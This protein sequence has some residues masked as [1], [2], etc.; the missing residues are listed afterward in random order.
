MIT[1]IIPAYNE[2]AVIGCLLRQLMPTTN[3]GDVEIIVVAN[4]C[5]DDTAKIAASFGPPV[6]VLT[7]PTASKRDALTV[8][9]REACGFPRIYIDADVEL[10][11]SGIWALSSA[12]ETDGVLAALPV[13]VVDVADSTWPVRWYYDIWNRVPTVQSGLFGRGVVAVNETGHRRITELPPLLADDL[14]ASLAFAD[15]ER[16]IVPEARVIVHAPRTLRDHLRRRMRV[17]NGVIQLEH[18]PG[19]PEMVARTRLRD[20]VAIIKCEPRCAPQMMIFLVVTLI[21]RFMSRRSVRKHGYLTW[22]RDESS[23]DQ[24]RV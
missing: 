9:D 24:T 19:A 18:T 5:I 4:G 14:A 17:A 20:L 2:H 16:V 12:L 1:I 8:G 7:S 22:F 15:S 23:R 13:R 6:R 21:V 11:Y 3:T 10:E